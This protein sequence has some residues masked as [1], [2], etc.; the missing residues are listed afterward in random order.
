M[1]SLEAHAAFDSL[2]LAMTSTLV[3][4][5][6]DF[7]KPFVIELDASGFGHG[8]VLT[9]EKQPISFFSHVHTPR[10][11]LKHAYESDLMAVVMAVQKWK[12]Y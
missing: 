11:Q 5:L 4:A 1:W 6:P 9:E 2:K 12:H 3:L 8:A 10:E 7:S